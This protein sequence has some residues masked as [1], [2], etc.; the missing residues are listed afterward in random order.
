MEDRSS[1]YHAWLLHRE[2]TITAF[3]T[4]SSLP[5]E[6]W[7]GIRIQTQVKVSTATAPGS[8]LKLKYQSNS[9]LCLTANK[10]TCSAS[11]WFKIRWNSLESILQSLGSRLCLNSC[12]ALTFSAPGMCSALTVILFAKH[13]PRAE[14]PDLIVVL[15][16]TS[17][18]V[19]L[20][21]GKFNYIKI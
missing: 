10:F 4:F 19:Y 8:G 13:L 16:Q 9:T 11:D 7:E 18:F 20:R 3:S 21:V 12:S 5:L 2:V 6:M 14:L 17:L 1:G 15:V